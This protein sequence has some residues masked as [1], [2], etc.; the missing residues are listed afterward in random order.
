MAPASTGELP[1]HGTRQERGGH[2][3]LFV[4][5]ER[6]TGHATF[7]TATLV[8]VDDATAPHCVQVRILTFDDVTVL[9]PLPG[10]NVP[11]GSD[12]QAFAGTLMLP[13]GWRTPLIPDDLARAAAAA[14]LDTGA[15]SEPEARQLLT[16]LGEAREGSPVRAQRIAAIIS[17]LE[18]QR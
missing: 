1:V 2:A 10:Q 12:G 16:F 15:W 13:H 5:A 11:A 4:L 7:L 8:V 9:S 6:L 18:A 17:A 14:G 3:Q